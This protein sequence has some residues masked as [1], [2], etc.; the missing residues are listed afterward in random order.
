MAEDVAAY[1]EA[2]HMVA[3]WELG[4]AV[5]GATIVA[6]P[7]EGYAGCVWNPVEDRVHYASWVDENNYLYAHLVTYYA[8]IAASEI[9][10]GAPLSSEARPSPPFLV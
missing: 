10:T 3:A 6:N 4:L 8:G 2:G 5:T 1:H 9:Y 7:E